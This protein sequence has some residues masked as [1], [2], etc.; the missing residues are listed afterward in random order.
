MP[1]Q[2]EKTHTF[3]KSGSTFAPEAGTQR[4][5]YVIN[6][7]VTE[8]DLMK[9][10]SLAFSGGWNNIKLYFMIELPNR[11]LRVRNYKTASVSDE[12]GYTYDG[13]GNIKTVKTAGAKLTKYDYDRFGNVTKITDNTNMAE[14]SKYEV[15]GYIT[16]KIFR[17]GNRIKYYYDA[18]GHIICE[19]AYAPGSASPE[20]RQN[21][22]FAITG[23]K[24]SENINNGTPSSYAYDN[25][26]QLVLQIDGSATKEYTYDAAGNRKTFWLTDSN[27][28]IMKLGYDYDDL[29]RL[30]TLSENSILAAS[31]TYDDNGNLKAYTNQKNGN[32][33]TYTYNGANMVTAIAT[34]LGALPN[35]TYDYLANGLQSKKTETLGGITKATA[36]GYDLQGRLTSEAVGGVTTSYQY[37]ADANRSNM[38]VSG[39]G[40]YT[41]AYAYDGNNR[42]EKSTKTIGNIQE[43]TNYAYDLN[44]NQISS[45]V[46]TLSSSSTSGSGG[47]KLS[48]ATDVN[49]LELLAYNARNQLTQ[50]FS[51][52]VTSAYAYRPDGLRHSK[53]VD[54]ATTRHIWDGANMA[55]ETGANGVPGVPGV[56]ATAY[57]RGLGIVASKNLSNNAYTGYNLNAH[58]DVVQLTNSSGSVIRNYDYDAFGNEK[59]PDEGSSNPFRYDGEFFDL[60]SGVYTDD[61]VNFWQTSKQNMSRPGSGAVEET[62]VIGTV[63]HAVANTDVLSLTPGVDYIL[64]F[65]Y[66][67][68]T[69]GNGFHVDLVTPDWNYVFAGHKQ[70][71][72]T[73]QH[74]QFT[75]NSSSPFINNVNLRF[76]YNSGVGNNVGN[77]YISNVRLYNKATAES[78]WYLD[79]GSAIKIGDFKGFSNSSKTTVVPPGRI[80]ATE[81]L[82]IK[83]INHAVASTN[84]APLKQVLATPHLRWRKKPVKNPGKK[85]LI[86]GGVKILLF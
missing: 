42:L 11:L 86:C 59:A 29:G 53:T 72:K 46:D 51:N 13:V 70:G 38:T 37:D 14:E 8:E 6:K 81:A 56:P 41:V 71:T 49:G 80:K 23:A 45:W 31:Y 61:F 10:V 32:T 28:S 60:S 52:G 26:G 66:W 48:V 75:I 16:E 30:K 68:D 79:T 85:P 65:D 64:E 35:Y 55:A 19:E 27:S 74:A 47:V 33:T 36:Y 24:L 58:G 57:I 43:V 44:G 77:V 54:G 84:A 73:P 67:A 63:E 34:S 17:A 4:L 2:M 5:R 39:A 15:R 78:G 76:F 20:S 3:R 22:S 82:S 9:S 62:L 83:P 50:S 21:Y 12:T 40:G 69:N 25:K 1:I 18:M 7:G